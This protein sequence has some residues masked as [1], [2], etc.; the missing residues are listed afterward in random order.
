MNNAKIWLWLGGVV[1]LVG[2]FGAGWGLRPILQG[3]CTAQS[4]P[5]TLLANPGPW[6]EIDYTPIHLSAPDELLSVRT[7]EERPLHWFFGSMSTA[8]VFRTLTTLGLTAEACDR[9]IPP[10]AIKAT[11]QGT[12]ATPVKAEVQVL[13]QNVRCG[14]YKILGQFIENGDDLMCIPSSKIMTHLQKSGLSSA[15][16][17]TIREWSCNY[18]NYTQIYCFPCLLAAIP[19]ADQKKRLMKAMSWEDSFLLRLHINRKTNVDALENY[20]GRA[21]WTMDIEAFLQ[22]LAEVPDGTWLD[23]I[24]LLPPLPAAQLYT[25]PLPQNPLNGPVV[26]RDCHWTTFNFFRDPPDD[27]YADPAF[28]LEKLKTEFY[29]VNAD[30]RYGDVVLFAKP[31]GVTI[32]SAVFL[33]DNFVFS[34][35]GFTD[36][37]PWKITT[38]E[39]LK[40]YYSFMVGPGQQLNVLYFRNK[41]Y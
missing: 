19:D 15:T 22:S 14:I 37:H 27:H 13:A 33:A 5:G 20:W 35:N 10:T 8:D 11:P 26:R 1:L 16:I 2:M 4:Q 28:V 40:A 12:L 36:L 23:V 3:G 24:E 18:S 31:D 6:G 17:N 39:N 21:C 7:L 29:P 32:H 34:K 38:I 9:L 30:P 41:Y 25:Y